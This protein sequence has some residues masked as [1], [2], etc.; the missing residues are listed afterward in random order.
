MKNV[1]FLCDDISFRWEDETL[2]S[3]WINSVARSEDR[4]IE[5]FSVVFCSDAVLL[6][7][8]KQYLNHDFY[9]DIVTFDLS[10]TD[11][12]DGEIY[13]SLDRIRDNANTHQVSAETELCRVI[14]H[15][16]LH[17]I[18]Y[19]DKTEEL[20]QLMQSKEDACLS[21]LSKVPRG[22]FSD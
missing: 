2:L 3:D 17:L 21:L 6:Q 10:E 15:G 12:I 4:T 1:S 8:N 16:L 18:G 5:N 14:I 11:A 7:I 20:K 22:T 19:D 9:T 13:V